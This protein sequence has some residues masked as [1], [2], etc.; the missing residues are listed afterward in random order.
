MLVRYRATHQQ[1][2]RRWNLVVLPSPSP[3]LVGAYANRFLVV[4]ARSTREASKVRS[5]SNALT[6]TYTDE[7]INSAKG[8][9]KFCLLVE[10]TFADFLASDKK[11][12]VLPQMPPQRRKFVHDLADVF[13]MDTQMVD[14]EP[15]R[16]VQLIKRLDSRIPTPLLSASASASAA[17]ASSSTAS[18]GKLTD[19][20][21]QTPRP[22]WGPGRS[23]TSTPIPPQ[24]TGTMGRR[25]WTAVVASKPQAH[26]P[27]RSSPTPQRLS[28][29][30]GGRT[31]PSSG[32]SR[33]QTPAPTAAPMNGPVTASIGEGAPSTDPQD[34]PEDWEDDT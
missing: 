22:A 5:S 33:N 20:R 7:L 29:E 15:Y 14:Q 21:A 31:G 3:V 10:K 2:V 26:T 27:I 6:I 16:S 24:A 12:Q 18:L 13:R 34:V 25:G 32:S 9:S 23:Q 30:E 11:N 4:G 1:R 19:L 17:S 8:D 28:A